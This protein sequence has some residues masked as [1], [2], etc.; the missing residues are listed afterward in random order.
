M[1]A[2]ISFRGSREEKQEE[3]AQNRGLPLD[4][5]PLDWFQQHVLSLV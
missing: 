2:E 3:L 1:H 5:S 4:Q